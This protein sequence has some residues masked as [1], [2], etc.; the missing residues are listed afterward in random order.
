MTVKIDLLVSVNR[1]ITGDIQL[2]ERRQGHFLTGNLEKSFQNRESLSSGDLIL[3]AWASGIVAIL[4]EGVPADRIPYNPDIKSGAGTSQYIQGLKRYA[5]L[6]FGVDEKRGLQIAFA[7]A[8]KH[9]AE[10]MP[11]RGSYAFSETGERTKAVYATFLQN[12]N[13]YFEQV[14]EAIGETLDREWMQKQIEI[15]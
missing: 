6:R 1:E 2:E 13:K 7:I 4:E 14:D 5:M 8:H 3:E 10:G 12:E 9:K 15:I 11:T